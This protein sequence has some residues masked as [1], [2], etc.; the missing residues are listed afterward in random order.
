MLNDRRLHIVHVQE[1][2]KNPQSKAND[3]GDCA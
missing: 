2:E 1:D 3:L